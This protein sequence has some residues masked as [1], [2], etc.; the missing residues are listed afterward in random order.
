MPRPQRVSIST[1]RQF[2]IE[3]VEDDF[4]LVLRFRLA[5]PNDKDLP[6]QRAKLSLFSSVTLL[7]GYRLVCPETGVRC[8]P[9][10]KPTV[11]C[12]PETPVD[13]YN[14]AAPR[15]HEVR[16]PR[17]ATAAKTVPKTAPVNLP[18]NENFQLR[19]LLLDTTHAHGALRRSQGIDHS[20]DQRPVSNGSVAAYPNTGGT[21]SPIHFVIALR[22]GS[23]PFTTNSKLSG[24]AW[25]RAASCG[26]MTR[27]RKGWM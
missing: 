21:A 2:P 23:W 16:S 26:V 20:R 7:V 4:Q 19:V 25:I 22:A 15:K 8:R 14:R 18:P 27:G 1:A 6:A 10:S 3:F 17:Q 24:K 9:S 12:M 13:E 11:V 5:L